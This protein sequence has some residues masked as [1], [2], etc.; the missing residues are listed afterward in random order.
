MTAIGDTIHLA[1]IVPVPILP[2]T[3]EIPFGPF[4]PALIGFT[5]SG[6]IL[7]TIKNNDGFP[8]AGFGSLN[9]YK[10]GLDGTTCRRPHR[11]RDAASR[12]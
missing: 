3:P 6:D 8:G 5:P 1:Q 7:V 10:I 11:D 9:R 12:L 2:D 4:P